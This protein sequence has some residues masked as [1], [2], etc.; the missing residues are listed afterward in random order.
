[1]K[2]EDVI[3]ELEDM[4]SKYNFRIKNLR[5]TIE[6]IKILNDKMCKCMHENKD[7]KTFEKIKDNLIYEIDKLVAQKESIK[8]AILRI[9]LL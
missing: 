3:N 4:I 6:E 1:M 7:A 2:K 8:E 5:E 9:D